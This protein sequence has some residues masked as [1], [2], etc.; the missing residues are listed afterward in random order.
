[1]CMILNRITYY[2]RRRLGRG[3]RRPAGGAR[4][5]RQAGGGI[6]VKFLRSRIPY[7]R[8]GC[9]VLVKSSLSPLG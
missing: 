3:D 7:Y 5:R 9:H 8:S 1:M 2:S 4:A 6:Y